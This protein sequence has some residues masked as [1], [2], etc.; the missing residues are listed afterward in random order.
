MEK[1]A[2]G[3]RAPAPLWKGS[4][5]SPKPVEKGL[6]VGELFEGPEGTGPTY[7]ESAPLFTGML[8]RNAGGRRKKLQ[9]C[10]LKEVPSQ[11]VLPVYM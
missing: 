10:C 8:L 9:L 3:A 2:G 6:G 4:M 5:G 1:R 7:E 11:D